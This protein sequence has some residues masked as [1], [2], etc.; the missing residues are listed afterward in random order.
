MYTRELQV[1]KSFYQDCQL[2]LKR[3]RD[4]GYYSGSLT[5]KQPQILQIFLDILPKHFQNPET[6]EK[7][8]LMEDIEFLLC[9]EH[10][11]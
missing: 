4:Q 8:E 6:T 7:Q 11:L 10:L 2:T 5:L 9:L 1:G 3:V